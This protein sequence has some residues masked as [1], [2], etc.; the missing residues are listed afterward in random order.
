LLN[1]SIGEA[2]L[3]QISAAAADSATACTTESA[4]EGIDA[5]AEKK[6]PQW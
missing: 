5:F 4:G 6:S 3:T 1:E 2:L